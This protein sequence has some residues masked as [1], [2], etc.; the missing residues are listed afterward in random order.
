MTVKLT[1][2]KLRAIIKEEVVKL[3]ES[4]L[5][6]VYAHIVNHNCAVLTGFR[7]DTKDFSVCLVNSSKT[8]PNKERNRELKAYLLKRGYGVTA[9]KGTYIENYLSD[10][11]VE[12]KEDSYFVVNL[13]DRQDFFEEIVKMGKF[14]CQDSILIIPKE[15]RDKESGKA[16]SEKPYL[17]GTNNSSFPG[18]ERKEYLGYF[19]GGVER[20]FMT[21][22]KGRPIVFEGKDHTLKLEAY[23]NYAKMGRWSISVIAKR[24]S[25]ELNKK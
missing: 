7:N 8:I 17:L 14:F 5:N 25:D 12:V 1:D 2:K 24:V 4:G 3:D 20:E 6:R 11:A 15:E 22:V 19:K 10:N 18:L 21:K 9:V 13:N 23:K 16:I